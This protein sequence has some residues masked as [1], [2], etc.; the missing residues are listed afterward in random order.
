MPGRGLPPYRADLAVARARFERALEDIRPERDR[1]AKFRFGPD[2]GA[3][4]TGYLALTNWLLGE[5]GRAR[6]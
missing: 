4:A 3:G 5:A 6:N 2:V 1:E